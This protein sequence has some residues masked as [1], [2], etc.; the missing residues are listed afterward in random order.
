MLRL[1]RI[2]KR[3]IPNTLAIAAALLL[4]ISALVSVE[5][6]ADSLAAPSLAASQAETISQQATGQERLAHAPAKQAR[7]FR[8]SLFLFRH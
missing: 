7:K 2:R 1:N 4:L 6:P 5:Q 3:H 8:I